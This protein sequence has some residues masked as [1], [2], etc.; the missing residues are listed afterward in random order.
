MADRAQN[1]RKPLEGST[2]LDALLPTLPP[3]HDRIQSFQFMID[4][5]EPQRRMV[6]ETKSLRNCFGVDLESIW[7]WEALS[8]LSAGALFGIFFWLLVD[9]DG[10]LVQTWGTRSRS[11]ALFKTLPSAIS[12]ITTLMRG[13]ILF[14][15]ASAMGQLK[16]H[17][18]RV[19]RRVKDVELIDGASRGY[20]GCARQILSRTWLYVYL[21]DPLHVSEDSANDVFSEEFCVDRLHVRAWHAAFGPF[22]SK[23]CSD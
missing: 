3:D 7:F 17:H 8:L 16:W 6:P 11:S 9:Y 23:Y 21:P 13:A 2:P 4:N 22:S 12:F 18:F 5:D 15:L 19:A 10:R 20:I 1:T 14:P